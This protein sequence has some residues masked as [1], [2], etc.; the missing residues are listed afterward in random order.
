MIKRLL[1]I[2][3]ACAASTS[4]AQQSNLLLVGQGNVSS[5]AS[6]LTWTLVQDSNSNACGPGVSTCT[7]Y[8]TQSSTYNPLPNLAGTVQALVL[9]TGSDATITSA[10][11]CT[12][13]AGCTSGNATET[14]STVAGSACHAW[15]SHGVDADVVYL[16][17]SG[18]SAG[19]DAWTV[20]LS[21][22]TSGWGNVF[23]FEALPP[24]GYTGSFDSC[25]VSIQSDV[26][27]MTAAA[28]S[29]TATDIIYQLT[30]VQ[31]T[32]A[33]G[34]LNN[35][36]SPYLT[37]FNGNGICLN[38]TSG[39]A[40]T[41]TAQAAD[42]GAIPG[43]AFKSSAGT[44]TP[45]TKIFSGVQQ[46]TVGGDG[47][48]ESCSSSGCTLTL[49]QAT[50]SGNFGML[51]SAANLDG[52]ITSVTGA[53][54]WTTSTNLQGV[55]NGYYTSCVYNLSLTS[56]VS[57]LTVKTGASGTYGFMY[58]EYRRNDAKSWTVD[59]IPSPV[60]TSGTS[61]KYTGPAFSSATG[62]N[63]LRFDIFVASGAIGA[64]TLYY[65]IQPNLPF[66]NVSSSYQTGVAVV[67]D[68]A[69]FNATTWYVPSS[70]TTNSLMGMVVK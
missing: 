44:Y 54:T 40:P 1:A 51:C 11:G 17:S 59:Q 42:W 20:N 55:T 61:G 26:E 66:F 64:S 70:G 6:T 52:Y 25:G 3:L 30:A 22:A 45:L 27:T 14:F 57:S 38:C 37:D 21:T 23:L 31:D 4:L 28:T 63:D 29:P 15:N 5:A 50:G 16:N 34:E 49:S 47:G 48:T 12:T 68:T 24:S 69:N 60:S 18:A 53:G 41:F 39:T 19:T 33:A 8:T 58:L 67:P 62:T 46:A 56:G 35:W 65:G 9:Y 32:G 2:L 7:I 43:I 10:Y 36:S 13:S